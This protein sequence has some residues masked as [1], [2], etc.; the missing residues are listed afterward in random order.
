M[1]S[2]L[3]KD[4]YLQGLARKI[5]CQPSPEPQKRTSGDA[6]PGVGPGRARGGGAATL[7]VA[8]RRVD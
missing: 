6:P 1:A 7:P 4:A 2:L 8:L 5:C 3:A